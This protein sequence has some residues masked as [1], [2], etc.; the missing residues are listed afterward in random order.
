[1]SK[2]QY[3]QM[4]K[5][6]LMELPRDQMR[7]FNRSINVPSGHQKEDTVRNLMMAIAK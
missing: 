6:D 3:L 1:M 5:K 2:E 4:L 7:E